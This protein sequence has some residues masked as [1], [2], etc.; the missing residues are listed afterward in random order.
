MQEAKM[1]N[2]D[3]CIFIPWVLKHFL[4]TSTDICVFI[5]DFFSIRPGPS[6]LLHL[7]H[8][9]GQPTHKEQIMGSVSCSRILQHNHRGCEGETSDP[10]VTGRPLT[11][12]LCRTF[13]NGAF[14]MQSPEIEPSTFRSLQQPLHHHFSTFT[15][16]E[17]DY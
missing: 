10:S 12:K 17:T 2:N 13:V 4:Y 1:L 8:G 11:T 16:N 7:T 5:G 3:V 9:G 14:D 6:P 15:V